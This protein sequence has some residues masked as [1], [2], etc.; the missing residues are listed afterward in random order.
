MMEQSASE[1]QQQKAGKNAK[2][3]EKLG[4]CCLAGALVGALVLPRAAH[5]LRGIPLFVDMNLLEWA[6]LLLMFWILCGCICFSASAVL[7]YQTA[8]RRP[9]PGRE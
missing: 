1:E 4:F 6:G 7:R 8:P 3:L 2:R 5:S 9:K